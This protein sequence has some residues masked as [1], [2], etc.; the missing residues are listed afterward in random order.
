MAEPHPQGFWFQGSRIGSENLHFLKVPRW[1]LMPLLW[2]PQF[3]KYGYRSSWRGNQSFKSWRLFGTSH[4]HTITQTDQAKTPSPFHSFLGV[5][6]GCYD[7]VWTF[8]YHHLCGLQTLTK[9][10]DISDR[11]EGGHTH[12]R[13]ECCWKAVF[14]QG[15]FWS[16]I[17]GKISEGKRHF[18]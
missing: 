4:H 11:W 18:C 15:S 14:P 6:Q 2:G 5:S 9:G 13:W 17:S 7:L 16:T 1:Y 10:R 8:L 3:K 12:Y